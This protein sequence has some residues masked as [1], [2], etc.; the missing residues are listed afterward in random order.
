MSVMQPK[1]L[2][3]NMKHMHIFVQ[4]KAVS[5]VLNIFYFIYTVYIYF[6]LLTSFVI[7]GAL[8][9]QEGQHSGPTHHG[10]FRSSEV[11]T[12]AA[13]DLLWTTVKDFYG[14]L[15]GKKERT[16]AVWKE[17]FAT[18]TPQVC[19]VSRQNVGAART[20]LNFNTKLIDSR[21]CVKKKK[22]WCTLKTSLCEVIAITK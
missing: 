17:I 3:W 9:S 13:V 12:P 4:G 18:L 7:S 14:R 1:Y 5:V 22:S 21:C 15:T 6:S 11:W 16:D 19:T 2:M 20:L 8:S 10:G